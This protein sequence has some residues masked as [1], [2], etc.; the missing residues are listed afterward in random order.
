M[1]NPGLTP[2][3]QQVEQEALERVQRAESTAQ[4]QATGQTEEMPEGYNPDGTPIETGLI[5]GKF[6]SQEDLL[7]AYQELEKK[8]SQQPQQQETPPV[9]T[10]KEQEPPKEVEGKLS[11]E[12]FNGY[13]NEFVEKGSLSEDTY[14]D[15][16][17]KGLSKEFVDNYIAGQNAISQQI[18]SEVHS[19]V[20][21]E[22]AYTDLINWAKD[23]LSDAQKTE[24]NKRLTSGNV[25]SAKDTAEYV[26][27]LRNKAEPQPPVRIGG[28]SHSGNVNGV[29]PFTDRGDY[30]KAV[31]N[32]LY[33]RDAKYTNM[34][35]KRY[36]ASRKAGTV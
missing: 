13:Y 29:K 9:E 33:G 32:R 17:A 35:D 8:Q 18:I 12:E 6:K 16:E 4:A 2:E 25:Q 30:S 34:V 10:P 19:V 20:G 5:G 21:G 1:E 3:Q 23:N 24:L 15:L 14:K 11:T 36:L 26:M 31:S 27:Y 22:E 28:Q 7:Q